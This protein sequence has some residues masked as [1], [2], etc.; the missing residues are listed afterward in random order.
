[1]FI[2]LSLCVVNLLVARGD[3]FSDGCGQE[4]EMAA[5]NGTGQ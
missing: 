5:S 2:V 4:Q 3:T 1:V